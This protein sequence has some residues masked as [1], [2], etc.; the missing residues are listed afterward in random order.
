MNAACTP[1]TGTSGALNHYTI[2][3]SHW[4]GSFEHPEHMLKLMG[5]E[6]FTISAQKLFILTYDSYAISTKISWAHIDLFLGEV[7]IFL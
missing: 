5:M 4:D 1:S 7:R 2:E 6:L 3:A